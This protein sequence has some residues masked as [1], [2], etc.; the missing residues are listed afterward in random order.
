MIRETDPSKALSWV[1]KGIYSTSANSCIGIFL[2]GYDFWKSITGS[3][4]ASTYTVSAGC[5][6]VSST[7]L[8]FPPEHACNGKHDTPIQQSTVQMLFLIFSL[9]FVIPAWLKL[10]N[11]ILIHI[12]LK[13]NDKFYSLKVSDFHLV[14]N[15]VGISQICKGNTKYK[16]DLTVCK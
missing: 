5:F 6:C 4:P 16:Y 1:S 11:P 9:R 12:Y 7:G 8:L 10:Y 2:F 14:R 13:V 3:V 15:L